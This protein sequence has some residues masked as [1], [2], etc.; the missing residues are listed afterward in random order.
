[1]GAVGHN[2]GCHHGIV[3]FSIWLRIEEVTEGIL[4]RIT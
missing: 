4:N 1:M 3:H 2:C